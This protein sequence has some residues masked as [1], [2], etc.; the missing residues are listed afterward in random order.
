MT[1]L[2][3]PRSRASD[4]IAWPIFSTTGAVSVLPTMPRMS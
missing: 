1:T 2:V 4:P 3:R